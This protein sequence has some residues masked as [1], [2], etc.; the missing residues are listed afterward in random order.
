M[1]SSVHSPLTTISF[2][3]QSAPSSTI[4]L[5]TPQEPKIKSQTWS[6]EMCSSAES[7]PPLINPSG[8]TL[9]EVQSMTSLPI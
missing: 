4:S 9:L 5:P 6:C 1:A 7:E 8:V 3:P 2:T